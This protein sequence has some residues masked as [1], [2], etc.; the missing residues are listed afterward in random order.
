MFE[1]FSFLLTLFIL[2]PCPFFSSFELRNLLHSAAAVGK[3][4]GL[5][6]KLF[7]LLLLR[8]LI[9]QDEDL[10]VGSIMLLNKIL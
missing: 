5:E 8:Y 3:G 10:M 1:L 4:G 9:L 6:G 2:L 7:D